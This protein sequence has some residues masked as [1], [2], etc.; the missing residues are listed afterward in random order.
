MQE[1]VDDRRKQHGADHR[2]RNVAAGIGAFPTEV[3]RGAKAEKAEHDPRGRQGDEDAVGIVAA[4]CGGPDAGASGPE[5][6]N[7]MRTGEDEDDCRQQRHRDLP[8][9][10]RVVDG[11]QPTNGQKIE[12]CQDADQ[13]CAGNEAGRR[14]YALAADETGVKIVGI[15]H[16]AF[17]FDG[18]HRDI[19]EKQHPAPDP[20]QAF[21]VARVAHVNQRTRA[22]K[23]RGELC[24]AKGDEHDDDGAED[25]T[26][27]AERPGDL[28]SMQ[29]TEQPAGADHAGCARKQQTDDARV[30]TKAR[31]CPRFR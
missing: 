1:D 28:R 23:Q 21:A 5:R 11:Q 10:N 13:D 7:L 29:R 16:D 2:Q 9:G 3:D 17:R 22:G 4:R 15:C 31:P 6:S 26:Q 24:K 19:G 12:Q 30:A 18:G 20:P 14:Q 25:P 27:Q 8:P